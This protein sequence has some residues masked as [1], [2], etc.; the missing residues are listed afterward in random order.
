MED[1]YPQYP[2][3]SQDLKNKALNLQ[4]LVCL[5]LYWHDDVVFV[6]T[7]MVNIAISTKHF[8]LLK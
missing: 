8:E 5:K 3:L 2:L 7:F 1:K 4:V 6:C